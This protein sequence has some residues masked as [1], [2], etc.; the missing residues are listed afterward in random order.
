[1]TEQHLDLLDIT[2]NPVD[3]LL[4]LRGRRAKASPPGEALIVGDHKAAR[5]IQED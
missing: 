3:D 2:T 5:T 4:T 1:M